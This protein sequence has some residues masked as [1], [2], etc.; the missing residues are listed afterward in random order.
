MKKI[1]SLL[2]LGSF[3][4][5]AQAQEINI[6]TLFQKQYDAE[7]QALVVDTEVWR[8]DSTYCWTNDALAGMEAPTV[9]SYNLDFSEYSG[10]ILHEKRQQYIDGA[11]INSLQTRYVYDED[12]NKKETIDE[13]WKPQE[14]LWEFTDKNLFNFNPSANDFNDITSQRWEND[15]W[16]NRSQTINTFHPTHFKVTQSDNHLWEDNTWALDNRFYFSVNINTLLTEG[17]LFQKRNENGILANLSRTFIYYNEMG[18]DTLT[19]YELN[20]GAWYFTSRVQKEF[21]NGRNILRT[22]QVYNVDEMTWTNTIQSQTD[23]TASGEQEFVT[24]SSW[25][26]QENAFVPS[27][28][29]GYI[30]DT[31]DNLTDFTTDFYQDGAWVY[32]GRC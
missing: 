19:T 23:Y 30:Y 4:I 6:Q 27:Y 32:N 10:Q 26:V 17:I 7:M 1:I 14:N 11:W 24:V 18:N 29:T 21:E 31:A 16:N 8:V 20:N 22:D 12:D 25:N 28:R 15:M 5:S 13:D 9:R 2:L 3:F